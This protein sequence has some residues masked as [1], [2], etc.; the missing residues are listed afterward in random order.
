M[1]ASSSSSKGKGKARPASPQ[2]L[3]SII[4]SRPD[5]LERWENAKAET[6]RGLLVVCVITQPRWQWA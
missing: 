5:L 4:R 2:T 1:A 3:D 6:S